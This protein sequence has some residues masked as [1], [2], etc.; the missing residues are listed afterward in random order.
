MNEEGE[1]KSK[2]SSFD[3]EPLLHPYC[4]RTVLVR[5]KCVLFGKCDILKDSF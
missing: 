1:G 2:N 5:K 4:K 3:N